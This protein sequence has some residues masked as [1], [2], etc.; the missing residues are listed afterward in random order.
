MALFDHSDLTS[1]EDLFARI[2]SS[3]VPTQQ[4]QQPHPLS[5]SGSTSMLRSKR[6]IPAELRAPPYD[7]FAE[8]A[9]AEAD[10]E[11]DPFATRNDEVRGQDEATSSLERRD[12]ADERTSLGQGRHES[13][14][15]AQ[16]EVAPRRPRPSEISSMR[17]FAPPTSSSTMTTSR[18]SPRSKRLSLP[19]TSTSAPTSLNPL[20]QSTSAVPAAIRRPSPTMSS[21]LRDSTKKTLS[22]TNNHLRS[23]SLS[24]VHSSSSSSANTSSTRSTSVSS[25]PLYKHARPLS[26]LSSTSTGT[27]LSAPLSTQLKLQ[28]DRNATL[29][30]KASAGTAQ[31][32]RATERIRQLEDALQR[33]RDEKR[34]DAEGWEAEANR[35]A[36][37]LEAVQRGELQGQ[38]REGLDPASKGDETESLRYELESVAR[39]LKVEKSK[40][41]RAKEM[42]SKLKCE[43]INRRWKE[44][45]EVEL[46]EREERAW[47][48][49]LVERECELAVVRGEWACEKAEREELE[50]VVSA[51][52]KRISTLSASR[53]VLLESFR[54]SEATISTLRSQLSR[55]EAAFAE[56]EREIEETTEELDELKKTLEQEGKKE[57]GKDDEKVKEIKAKLEAE[58]KDL[59]AQLK[60]SQV[61][62]KASEKLASSTTRSLEST[63]AALATL[64][65]KYDALVAERDRLAADSSSGSST[66]KARSQSE[67]ARDKKRKAPEPEPEVESEQEGGPDAVEEEEEEVVEPPSPVSAKAKSKPTKRQ[68]KPTAKQ[69][70][71]PDEPT[72]VEGYRPVKSKS[73]S[74]P[75]AAPKLK[76]GGGAKKKSKPTVEDEDAPQEPE[77]PE[78]VEEEDAEEEQ[79]LVEQPSAPQA[80]KRKAN[81]LADKSTNGGSKAGVTGLKVKKTGG[82]KKAGLD[83]DEDEGARAGAEIKPS[84]PVKKKKRTLIAGFRKPIDWASIETADING[85]GLIPDHLSPIKPKAKK[86]TLGFAFGGGA[87]N[88]FA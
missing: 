60:S 80:K 16:E 63:Q 43:V 25:L 68:E 77:E 45:F 71:Q 83:L 9:E 44:K 36:K 88:I 10:V 17:S 21:T 40:K 22:P 11:Q 34:V 24:V 64:E 7:P 74:A 13:M 1:A 58:L 41:R 52:R 38:E 82:K 2:A 46:L 84:D 85:G 54:T 29:A 53:L 79:E 55:A 69:A 23:T 20:S 6:E 8:V 28:K 35:L 87:K 76:L 65:N 86:T 81:V 70:E 39:A 51:Q 47:E 50:S 73:R 62:L 5:E 75:V 19:L 33:E 66:V 4:Q 57:K 15:Q 78:P 37:E 48:I 26:H 56:K 32:A 14:E 59:K 42:I 30:H 49:K 61:S 67:K 12:A 18:G 31:L 27:L 72:T 3:P